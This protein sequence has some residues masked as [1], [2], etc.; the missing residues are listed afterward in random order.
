MLHHSTDNGTTQVGRYNYKTRVSVK[1]DGFAMA[2][3]PLPMFLFYGFA[4]AEGRTECERIM[5]WQHEIKK[6]NQ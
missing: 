2:S 5:L 1:S 4:M 6:F 3:I